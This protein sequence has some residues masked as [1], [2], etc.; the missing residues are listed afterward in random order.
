MFL[1][2]PLN[3]R[4]ISC[5]LNKNNSKCCLQ[6]RPQFL[7]TIK[8]YWGLTPGNLP[9]Y[10]EKKVT[11]TKSLRAHSEHFS[12]LNCCIH[13]VIFFNQFFCSVHFG[14]DDHTLKAFYFKDNS[15]AVATDMYTIKCLFLQWR[16]YIM[17]LT[18][19][20]G[21]SIAYSSRVVLCMPIFDFY[22][23]STTLL[24]DF[25]QWHSN[26]RGK[27]NKCENYF[28]K[29]KGAHIEAKRCTYMKNEVWCMVGALQLNNIVVL[30]WSPLN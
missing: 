23:A 8:E 17:S 7:R 1:V 30:R 26:K 2:L 4:L 22:Y 21:F 15:P 3:R 27:R 16:P 25:P 11:D 9:K 12:Q 10:L 29:R 24:V 20:V 14:C 19:L 13:F 6:R 28:Q 18:L 5:N